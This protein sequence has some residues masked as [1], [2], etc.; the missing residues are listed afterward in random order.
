MARPS[1]LHP[2]AA[3]ALKALASAAICAAFLSTAAAAFELPALGG[4]GPVGSDEKLVK[5]E[6]GALYGTD[7]NVTRAPDATKQSDSFQ[8]FHGGLVLTRGSERKRLDLQLHMRND[9]YS[10]LSGYDIEETRALFGLQADTK[11]IALSLRAGYA[12]LT[13]PTD[14]EITHLL[15]RTRMSL[16]PGI[17]LRLG[18]ALELSCGYS[19][20]SSEYEAPYDYLNYDETVLGAE[21]RLGRR[22]GGRQLFFHFDSGDFEYGPGIRDDDD[23]TFD[24]MYGGIRT[25]VSRSSHEFAVGTSNVET[26]AVPEGEIYVTYRSTFQLNK[27]RSLLVGV[28][29]GPE[30]AAGAEYKVATR[31]LASYRHQ[32]NTRWRFSLGVGYESSE[33]VEPLTVPLPYP[34][35]LNRITVDAGTAVEIGTPELLHGR[36]YLTVGYESRGGSDASVEYGRMRATGGLSLI[37]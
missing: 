20:V 29:Y 32:M 3:R 18:G 28:A 4:I 16:L 25:E 24:R 6:L 12:M 17:D 31:F 36:L 7:D 30:A 15:D 23:F 37:Y 19:L 14:I 22:K 34:S 1:P 21:L 8:R 2:D 13:D 26:S 35:E 9:K 27:T 10:E 11:S 5:L 33:F